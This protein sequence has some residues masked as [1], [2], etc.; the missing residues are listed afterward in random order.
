[1]IELELQFASIGEFFQ[2]GRYTFH[3]WAVYSLFA[4]FLGYNL[5]M[6]LWQRRQFIRARRQVLRREARRAGADNGSGNSM[7]AGS[8]GSQAGNE[9]STTT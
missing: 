4:V 8:S 1:M 3:V 5:L 7:G 6:P 2:M 9:G